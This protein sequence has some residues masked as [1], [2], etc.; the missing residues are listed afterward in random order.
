MKI[1]LNQKIFQIDGFT[2]ALKEGNLPLTLQDVIIQSML[3]PNQ[4]IKDRDGFII[5]RGDNQK[6]KEDKYKIYKK[7]KDITEEVDLAIEDL[8]VIKKAMGENQPQL[9]MGQCFD[10]LECVE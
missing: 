4:D 6:E 5:K 1:K 2:P 7:V 9:V 8:A 10:L 3:I